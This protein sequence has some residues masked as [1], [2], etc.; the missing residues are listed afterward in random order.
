MA[1]RGGVVG[2]DLAGENKAILH[3]AQRYGGESQKVLPPN[4]IYLA[5]KP[6]PVSPLAVSRQN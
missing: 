6:P 3:V 1:A 4:L 2:K 5:G